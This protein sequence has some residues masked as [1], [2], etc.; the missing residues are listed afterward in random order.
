VLLDARRPDL[1]RGE[2]EPKYAR[3]GHIPGAHSAHWRANLR[4]DGR[5]EAAADLRVRYK[6]LGVRAGRPAIVYCGSGMSACHDL[7]ALEV[8]GLPGARLYPGS[9]HE[10]AATEG[11]PASR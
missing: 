7:L 6:Q 3:A 5:F 2:A 11:A 9:W 1:F 10:W 8:A 4:P